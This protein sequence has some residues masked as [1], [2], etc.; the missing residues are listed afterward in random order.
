MK[1][2]NCNEIKI[3]NCN[4]IACFIKYSIRTYDFS[5]IVGLLEIYI[6]FKYQSSNKRQ[7]FC[8]VIVTYFSV[9]HISMFLCDGSYMGVNSNVLHRFSNPLIHT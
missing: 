8:I 6:S 1:L 2:K 4:E 9:S 7:K 5:I 3:K